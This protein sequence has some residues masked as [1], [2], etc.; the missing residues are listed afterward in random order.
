MPIDF[1]TQTSVPRATGATGPQPPE[2]P[3]AIPAKKYLGDFNAQLL[4]VGGGR[5]ASNLTNKAPQPSEQAKPVVSNTEPSKGLQLALDF[6]E[7]Y[8]NKDQGNN[9][10]APYTTR[11]SMLNSAAN[12]PSRIAHT[13][14]SF[15]K[16]I[17]D[18]LTGKSQQISSGVQSAVAA[19][20][21]GL[22][23]AFK[24][25]GSDLQSAGTKIIKNNP[26]SQIN[27]KQP[28]APVAHNPIQKT[29]SCLRFL[30]TMQKVNTTKASEALLGLLS[31]R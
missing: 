27:T 26:A 3:E 25:M 19:P 11:E 28:K 12:M 4:G 16:G 14:L 22:G 24:G 7:E 10:E 21:S 6:R 15:P 20:F 23:Q 31:H 13:A 30:R 29:S 5:V 9:V 2:Y 1:K 18:G 8:R 17:T